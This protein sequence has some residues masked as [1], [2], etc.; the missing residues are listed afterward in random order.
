[1][2][3]NTYKS[4]GVDIAAADKFIYQLKKMS[5]VTRRP[6]VQQG[7]GGFG[8]MF[9]LDL[10]RYKSPVFISS[11]DGVGTKLKI[12]QMIN[13]HDT[14]GIDLVAMNVNDILCCGAEPL[15][16]MD[17]LAVGKVNP[18]VMKSIMKGILRGCCLAGCALIGGETAEMPGIYE[19]DEYDLAGFCVG[20]AEKQSIIDGRRVLPGNKIIGIASNGVHSNGFSLVR[21]VFTERRLKQLAV[22]LLRPTYIYVPAV[23]AALKQH[24]IYAIAHITGGAFYDKIA[25]VVPD[26]CSAVINKKTWPRPEIFQTIQREGNISDDEM[27]R[28]FNMGVG[29][30]VIT[31]DKAV[32]GIV[33]TFAKYKYRSW[34][35]GEI[36]HGKAKVEVVG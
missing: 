4:A 3:K 13:Q 33:R 28:T 32:A 24:N 5:Q 16:F 23:L 15:F 22:K 29:M 35:I 20:I 11:C 14:I 31:E 21:K 30:I 25:R 18:R 2:L 7:I 19:K 9:A 34:E 10:K 27:Y 6:E 12:A 17:Y 8:G 26:N 36:T 1:M